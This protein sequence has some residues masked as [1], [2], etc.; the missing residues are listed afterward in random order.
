LLII[1]SVVSS[2][3]DGDVVEEEHMEGLEAEEREEGEQYSSG[4]EYEEYDD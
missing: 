3:G 2:D 4:L 1:A